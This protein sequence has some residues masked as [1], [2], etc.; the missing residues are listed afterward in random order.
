LK[1]YDEEAI[2]KRHRRRL[3]LAAAARKRFRKYGIDESGAVPIHGSGAPLP[4]PK[5]VNWP[6]SSTGLSHA[7]DKEKK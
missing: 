7:I 5:P 6:P 3:K 4:T 2:R 1:K